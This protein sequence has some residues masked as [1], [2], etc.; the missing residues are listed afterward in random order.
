MR[1]FSAIAAI[2]MAGQAWAAEP[3]P[4]P[5]PTKDEITA[6]IQRE[7]ESIY[8]S[9][10]NR[11]L[12][13]YTGVTVSLTDPVVGALAYRNLSY[14]KAEEPVWPV[15]TVVTTSATREGRTTSEVDV[16]G[17]GETWYFFQRDGVW[18][19]KLGS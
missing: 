16:R 13:H 10:T 1:L 4:W 11:S 17:E 19:Y 15:K 12:Y 7:M 5:A 8:L 18:S 9:E 2:T 14:E 3:A 6:T